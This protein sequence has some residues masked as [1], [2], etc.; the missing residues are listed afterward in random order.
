M[1]ERENMSDRIK[2]REREECEKQIYYSSNETPE[3]L[4]ES[5][6]CTKKH[7]DLPRAFLIEHHSELFVHA[8]RK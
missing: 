5:R 2:E 3:G 8:H 4:R 6:L 7:F 1:A